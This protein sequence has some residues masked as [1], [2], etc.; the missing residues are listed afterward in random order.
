MKR[1]P[2]PV[3]LILV[4]VAGFMIMTSLGYCTG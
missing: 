1:I 2:F 4:L 3:L